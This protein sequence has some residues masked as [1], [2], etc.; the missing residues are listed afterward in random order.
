MLN[1][2]L[3][4]SLLINIIFWLTV[5]LIIFSLV[6]FAAVILLHLHNAWMKYR[7][8]VFR[9]KWRP[10]LFQWMA[11]EITRLSS[12]RSRDANMMLDLWYKIRQHIDDS[13]AGKLND[14]A[15][16]LGLDDVVSRILQYRDPGA[17]NRKVWLQIQAIRVAQ[18]LNT[19]VTRVAL[20]R[21]ADSSNLLVNAEAT[22]AL[23]EINH[24]NAELEVL[25]T[26]L[27]FHQWAPYIAL[28]ISKA[29]GAETLHLAGR[30]LDQLDDEQIRN[31]TSL[32][33][34][35]DDKSLLPFLTRRLEKTTDIDEQAALLRAV[36]RLG[37]SSYKNH[38]LPYLEHP[39]A[40][41]R[42][43]A[44]TALGNIGTSADFHLLGPLLKDREWWVRYRSAQ[45]FLKLR[46]MTEN[47]LTDFLE[48]LTDPFARD[49]LRQAYAEKKL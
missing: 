28:K 18:A 26:L 42:T 48:T 32:I 15:L 20:L 40:I 21:A 6:L 43:T 39:D 38:V 33:E 12:L 9:R 29:G 19:P 37:G 41:L 4:E 46:P 3:A 2:L 30:Q 25:S 35:S 8:R 1:S 14:F 44:A 7:T 24:E 17:E 13:S 34:L 36:A 16:E 10:L 11:G 27:R 49:I 31:L 45:A 23:V 47:M 5:A 22:C